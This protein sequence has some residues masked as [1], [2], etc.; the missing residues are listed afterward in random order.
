M[1]GK[2]RDLLASYT[3]FFQRARFAK[4]LVTLTNETPEID[5]EGERRRV[6]RFVKPP[7]GHG[8]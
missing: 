2:A 4:P 1:E 3:D 6:R 5:R 7:D 8:E